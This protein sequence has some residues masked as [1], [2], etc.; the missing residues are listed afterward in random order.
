MIQY[1]VAVAGGGF[2]GLMTVAN[3][4][5][6]KGPKPKILWCD[7]ASDW[8]FGLAYSTYEMC[9]LLNVRAIKMG[10]YADGIDDFWRWLHRTYP[11]Q[12]TADDFAPRMI[13]GQYL[14]DIREN[15][16]GLPLTQK[17][18]GKTRLEDGV[19]RLAVGK[20]DATARHLVIATGN[21]PIA[22][23]GWPA[24]APYV[25]DFWRWRL[26]GGS[27]AS[28]GQAETVVIVGAGLTAADAMLGLLEDGFKGR[29]IC[30]SPHGRM[31]EIHAIAP[32]YPDAARL[33]AEL[34]AAPTALGYYRT[35]RRHA[36]DDNWRG[37]IDAVRAATP[38]FWQALPETEKARFM[39]HLWSRWN[40][41]RHRMAPQ[42]RAAL[43]G[44][45]Q[46]ELL[47]GRLAQAEPDG[48]LRLAL[49]HGGERV[50]KAAK[51]LNCT[52]PSYRRLIAGNPLLMSLSQGGHMKPGPLG[53]GIAEP[54]SDNLHA[55]GTPLLGARFE[56]T[57]VPELRVQAA[58]VAAAVLRGV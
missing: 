31:P 47:A 38:Q 6:R 23:L 18:I 13:Y 37:V 42:I 43:D 26:E 51:V 20:G 1:D 12:Y 16:A 53:L 24:T 56:T 34:Q 27:A 46:V 39:R 32:D 45:G 11:G 40:I 8:G 44:S 2:A 9:H 10:A 21:P 50:V 41:R 35:M 7:P 14:G 25:D 33:V 15:F 54:E 36:R 28:L 58:E 5:R 52:G 55:L 3:L 29:M 22:S 57:A 19:W 30:V 49:R 48:T 4:M 17:A